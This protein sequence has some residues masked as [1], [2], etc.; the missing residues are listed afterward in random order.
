MPAV[1]IHF[2]AALVA[3]LLF[4]ETL[5]QR[6]Q[7]FVETAHGLDLLF[8]F[9]G[10]IFLGELF[11]PLGRNVGFDHAVDR[12]QPFEHVTEHAIELV[13]IALVL[14]QRGARQIVKIVNAARR[15]IGVHGFEQRQ[16]FAQ[17]HRHAGLL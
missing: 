16:I 5:A 14:H 4:G 9:L 11:Q 1:P 15:Q 17:G 6:L 12:L 8:F 3:L 7:Q 2:D 10:Q 13:D